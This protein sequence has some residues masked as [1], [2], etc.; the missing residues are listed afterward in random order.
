LDISHSVACH[1]LPGTSCK[2][3][4]IVGLEDETT[5]EETVNLG[6]F[7]GLDSFTMNELEG[8]FQSRDCHYQEMLESDEGFAVVHQEAVWEK[9][10]TTEEEKDRYHQLTDVEHFFD[11]IKTQVGCGASLGEAPRVP[12]VVADDLKTEEDDFWTS[13]SSLGVLAACLLVL[14]FLSYCIIKRFR[15]RPGYSRSPRMAQE[16]KKRSPKSGED[17]WID[18]VEGGAV[19]NN[20][21]S[22][23]N[24]EDEKFTDVD[25]TSPQYKNRTKTADGKAD[26]PADPMAAAAKKG[27]SV[28]GMYRVGQYQDSPSV[29]LKPQKGDSNM[30]I[31]IKNLESE[32][33]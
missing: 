32:L 29:K 2:D 6:E 3:G 18:F 33:V 4:W 20:L 17:I 14:I 30:E 21:R 9:C 12:V 26:K 22:P 24:D 7:D 15:A 27:T 13:E 1:V 5:E 16:W 25:L 8:I 10:G 19:E 31:E 23:S 11:L 28:R